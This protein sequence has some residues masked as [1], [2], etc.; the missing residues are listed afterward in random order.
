[1][2]HNLNQ[3]TVPFLS[4]SSLSKRLASLRVEDIAKSL[5]TEACQNIQMLCT[6]YP[7]ARIKILSHG[8]NSEPCQLP[9]GCVRLR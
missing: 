4:L 3:N 7:L 5:K 8:S 2:L 1:M 6:G 9:R